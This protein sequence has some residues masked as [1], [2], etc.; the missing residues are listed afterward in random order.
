M[1]INLSNHP[2]PNWSLQQLTAAQ[3]YGK[4]IDLPFPD[5]DPSGDE[6][7]IQS[8]VSDY[9]DLISNNS[10]LANAERCS[11][12]FNS[13]L[14]IHIMGEMTFT[15]AMVNALQ[16]QGITCVASTTGRVSSEENGVKISEFQFKQ[17]RKYF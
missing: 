6:E 2:S 14:Y 16:K 13:H 12:I 7:Y 15:F 8:L 5:V 11:S 17:F 4:I 9:M 10:Q 3:V 1:L